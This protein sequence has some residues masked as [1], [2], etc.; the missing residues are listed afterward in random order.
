MFYNILQY[1][2]LKMVSASICNKYKLHLTT[3]YI[4]RYLHLF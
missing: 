3:I 2:E 4:Y 1:T